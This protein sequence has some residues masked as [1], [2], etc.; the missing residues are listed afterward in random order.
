MSVGGHVSSTTT[1][2]MPL[3]RRGLGLWRASVAGALLVLVVLFFSLSSGQWSLVKLRPVVGGGGG[4]SACW[5]SN[6]PAWQLVVTFTWQRDTPPEVI[7]TFEREWNAVADYVWK[8]E[9]TTYVS[10]FG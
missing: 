4:H 5:S 3:W 1:T 2:T 9:P 7:S 10:L 6:D 8:Y